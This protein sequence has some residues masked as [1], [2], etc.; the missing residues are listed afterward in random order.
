MCEEIDQFCDMF[1]ELG[2]SVQKDIAFFAAIAIGFEPQSTGK[3]FVDDVPMNEL[4]GFPTIADL[5][6]QMLRLVHESDVKTDFLIPGLFR[7]LTEMYDRRSD[8]D[9]TSDNIDS[10]LRLLEEIKGD[11]AKPPE[12]RRHQGRE[13]EL[14]DFIPKL[15]SLI[16]NSRASRERA[17]ETLAWL[18]DQEQLRFPRQYWQAIRLKHANSD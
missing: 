17:A 5:K 1:E 3:P 18:Q 2:D 13:A 14:R 15:E 8:P 10:N 11:L 12:M 16:A 9:E 7:Y 6:S 4:F